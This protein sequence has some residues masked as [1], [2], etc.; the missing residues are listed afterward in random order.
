M[1]SETGRATIDNWVIADNKNERKT[2]KK[3]S[4]LDD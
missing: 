2:E 1:E 3:S 4:S